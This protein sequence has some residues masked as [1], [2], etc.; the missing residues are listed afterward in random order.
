MDTT[1][2]PDTSPLPDG[3][4]T[5]D[6]DS[7]SYQRMS[8]RWPAFVVL[9]IAV[10]ILALGAL[11]SILSSSGKPTLTLRSVTIS[12][13]T[14][15]QV[16]PASVALRSI[17]A[18]G[19]PPA[20]ILAS[21]AVPAGST[22]RQSINTDQNLT[23]FDRTV[24]FTTSLSNSQILSFYHHLLP[25]LGWRISYSGPAIATQATVGGLRQVGA[26]TTEVLAKRSSTDGYYW[27]VGTVVSAAPARGATSYSVVLF[28]VPESA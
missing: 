22:V 28:E 5:V 1:H 2:V 10:F 8:L 9:G 21:L 15:V 26:G 16:T 3:T 7:R 11:A 25:R 13:G 14:V 6:P 4:T 17:S 19:Q 12:G 18:G 23:Q 24:D 20:D 27:E